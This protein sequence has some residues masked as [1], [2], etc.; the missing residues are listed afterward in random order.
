MCPKNERTLRLWAAGY[1]IKFVSK[2]WSYNDTVDIPI[3][4]GAHRAT[5]S[6]FVLL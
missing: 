1:L 4:E 6:F 2:Y 3:T 5:K